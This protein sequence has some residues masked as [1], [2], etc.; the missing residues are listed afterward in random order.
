MEIKEKGKEG[1]NMEGKGKVRVI[2]R[3]SGR[4]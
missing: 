4:T 3:I 1:E 2:Q